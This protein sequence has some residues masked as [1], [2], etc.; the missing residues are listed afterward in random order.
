M[1]LQITYI[2]ARSKEAVHHRGR[3]QEHHYKGSRYRCHVARRFVR[4]EYCACEEM[5]CGDFGWKI[6]SRYSQ[7]ADDDTFMTSSIVAVRKTNILADFDPLLA[8]KVKQFT[9]DTSFCEKLWSK[10]GMIFDFW[11]T[12]MKNEV[13]ISCVLYFGTAGL[14]RTYV[15]FFS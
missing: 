15:F 4:F 1:Y 11:V 12:K 2:Q 9:D 3:E 14:M 5:I 7:I 6:T 10:F 13:N 8:T